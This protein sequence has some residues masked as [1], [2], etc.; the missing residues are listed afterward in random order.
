[1]YNKSPGYIRASGRLFKVIFVFIEIAYIISLLTISKSGIVR[2]IGLSVVK[3]AILK[4]Y[5]YI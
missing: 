4:N 2:K 1:M 5:L 3:S